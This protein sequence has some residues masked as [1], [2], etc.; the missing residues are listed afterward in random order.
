MKTYEIQGAQGVSRIFVGERLANLPQHLP[1]EN[2]VI[3]TDANVERHH[4]HRFPPMPVLSVEPGEGSKSLE[5]VRQLYS[6]LVELEVDRSSF[7]V[8]IGGGVVCDIAG[9][10]AS[11]FMRGIPFGFAATSL[12][13][14]VDASV[15][16][17]NGVDFKGYKNIVG[18]F[19]Q[20]V[21]V[22]CDPLLLQ[23]LPEREVRCGLAEVVKHATIRDA[24][25]FA[26]LEQNCERIAA[27]EP[28]AV[29][30]LVA[31]SVT[32]KA[33]L[34]N[35]DER[36][37]GVRR[38]LNFGHT[39]GHAV[40]RHLHISHGE[41]VSI[42]MVA[43]AELSVRRRLLASEDR[44]RLTALLERLQLPIRADIDAAV[45]IDAIRKDKKRQVDAVHFVLLEGIGKAVVQQIP[46]D[47]L[48][49]FLSSAF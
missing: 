46:F 33:A 8:G 18:T 38:T 40:E 9:F 21:F 13:A 45:I 19:R 49:A 15:G 41:A 4:S 42:G 3:I 23:T 11:T 6:R 43:A 22:L 20:P 35:R 48:D 1:T 17:K 44:D 39:I 26:F 30:R 5:T 36:E 25:L 7:V 14:Q 34:V 37:Q 29:E 24:D 47:E 12:L 10:V 32:I 28:A 27:L 16:G 2:A 31:D